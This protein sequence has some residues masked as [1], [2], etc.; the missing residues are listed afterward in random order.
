MKEFTLT[1]T[2][3]EVNVIGQLLSQAPWNVANS[4]IGKI[5]EQVNQQNIPPP[6]RQTKPA[7]KVPEKDS[8]DA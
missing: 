7:T 4:L 2:E 5:Q 6:S 1:I 3:A 8:S